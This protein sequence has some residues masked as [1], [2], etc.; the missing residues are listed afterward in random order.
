[1]KNIAY[2]NSRQLPR[3]LSALVCAVLL[4]CI[5]PSMAAAAI[6]S[7]SVVVRIDGSGPLDIPFTVNEVRPGIF[8]FKYEPSQSGEGNFTIIEGLTNFSLNATLDSDPSISYGIAVTDFGTPSTFSFTFSVPIVPIGFPNVVSTSIAG[9]MVDL[10]GDG[11]SVAPVGV[12]AFLQVAELGA[13]S[14]SFGDVGPAVSYPAGAQGALYT[15]G[16]F[17]TGPASGPG[18]GPWTSLSLRLDFTASGNGDVVVLAGFASIVPEPTSGSLLF[19]GVLGLL[20]STRHR[21]YR[22][23]GGSNV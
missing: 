5:A 19:L 21:Q 3:A 9:A 17:A 6:T 18:P 13:P 20:A 1:M 23:R 10:T 4:A 7:P 16:A 15:Y 12:S 8:E 2:R 14:Q 22:P 11:V